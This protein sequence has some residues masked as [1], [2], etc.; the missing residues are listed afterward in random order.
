MNGADT[1]AEVVAQAEAVREV[2]QECAAA[3]PPAHERGEPIFEVIIPSSLIG[4][5][6]PAYHFKI[7]ADG[8]VDGFR[9]MGSDRVMIVNRLP[10]AFGNILSPLRA[11][12]DECEAMVAALQP[13]EGN[14]NG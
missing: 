6:T 14:G 4:V 10:L 3:Q 13:D 2:L 8:F 7:W 11:Y 12:L 5:T 9:N 1:G